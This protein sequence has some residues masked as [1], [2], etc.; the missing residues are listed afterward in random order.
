MP[1]GTASR[2]YVQGGVV[3]QQILDP[4]VVVKWTSMWIEYKLTDEVGSRTMDYEAWCFESRDYLNEIY[5]GYDVASG[6]KA[7]GRLPVG[8]RKARHVHGNCLLS[9]PVRRGC[10]SVTDKVKDDTMD[11]EA[12]VCF[13]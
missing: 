7:S 3:W 8:A 10:G 1:V 4:L 5:D 12:C 9:W 2:C 13:D 6:C 11:D